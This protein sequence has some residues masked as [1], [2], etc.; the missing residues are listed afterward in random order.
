MS[1]TI[2]K[3]YKNRNQVFVLQ[4]PKIPLQSSHNNKSK[5]KTKFF[6]CSS[7]S[8]AL[9]LPLSNLLCLHSS[10]PLHLPS[11]SLTLILVFLKLPLPWFYL[12]RVLQETIPRLQGKEVV[13]IR[14]LQF[15]VLKFDFLYIHSCFAFFW[16]FLFVF[17]Q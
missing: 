2:Y 14:K 13:H 6:S 9:P 15:Y 11:I 17:C 10:S 3:Y 8:L 7:S 5:K 1:P 16:C 12:S 4:C